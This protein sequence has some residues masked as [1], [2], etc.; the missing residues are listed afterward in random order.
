MLHLKL[1]VAGLRVLL[2]FAKISQVTLPLAC[3][4]PLIQARGIHVET[5]STP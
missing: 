5:L 4:F 2:P 1:S 3:Y